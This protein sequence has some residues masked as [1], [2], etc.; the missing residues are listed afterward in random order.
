M[1]VIDKIYIKR[2]QCKRWKYN[3]GPQIMKNLERIKKR[4]ID[5]YLIHCLNGNL[6]VRNIDNEMYVVSQESLI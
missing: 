2:K 6:K 3:Y 1:Y 5:W 4:S